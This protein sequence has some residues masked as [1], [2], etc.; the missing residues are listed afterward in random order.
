MALGKGFLKY[1]V[2]RLASPIGVLAQ[3][4]L[5]GR[6]L[7]PEEFARFL[8]AYSLAAIFSQASDGGQHVTLFSAIRSGALTDPRDIRARV[9]GALV[10]KLIAGLGWAAVVVLAGM[11]I[12]QLDTK[13][14]LTALALG[15]AMPVGDVFLN[16][17]RGFS[18]AEAEFFILLFEYSVGVAA[19]YCYSVRF[20]MSAYAAL[21]ILIGLGAARTVAS[22]VLT[23]RMIQRGSKPREA[24]ALD[25]ATLGRE[26]VPV[27]FAALIGVGFS[28]LPSLT[29]HGSL[30]AVDYAVLIAFLSL[31]G[32]G[33]LVVS[34]MLQAGF[35]SGHAA[36]RTL[37]ERRYL[38]LA[39]FG[40]LAVPVVIA[41]SLW[42]HI[43][44]TVYLGD[45]YSQ[46]SSLATVAALAMLIYYPLYGSRLLL[47]FSGRNSNVSVGGI[48]G[49]AVYFT[50][51]Q[52]VSGA[53]DAWQLAPYLAGLG[54]FLCVCVATLLYDVRAEEL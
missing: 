13:L 37:S 45:A 54:S 46:S 50:V 12:P 33:E 11:A 8:L 6:S 41:A 17:L 9:F 1:L 30:E 44:T 22:F 43:I 19:L 15:I 16:A 47:Q 26:A 2:V 28:R 10:V 40:S 49:A 52:L 21:A 7:A 48:V 32:R 53:P 4:A 51:L 34:A 36:W 29:L 35:R 23:R 42:P 18:R 20:P 24:R 25:L 5:L 27:T 31:F 14:V 3:F 39:L 38:F